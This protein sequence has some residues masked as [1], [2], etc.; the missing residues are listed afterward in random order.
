MMVEAHSLP[1]IYGASSRSSANVNDTD[2]PE[3]ALGQDRGRTQCHASGVYMYM[4]H[5]P[6]HPRDKKV[7]N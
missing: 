7:S 3:Y 2:S 6:W 4:A 1:I 5:A